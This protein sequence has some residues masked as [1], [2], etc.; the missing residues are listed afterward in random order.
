MELE[1]VELTKMEGRNQVELRVPSYQKIFEV[2]RAGGGLCEV[3]GRVAVVSYVK[4]AS[5]PE[6][7]ML[8]AEHYAPWSR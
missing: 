5:A 4:R 1:P 7:H 6:D 3:Q 2:K 8:T